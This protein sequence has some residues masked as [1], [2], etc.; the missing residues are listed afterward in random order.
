MNNAGINWQGAPVDM[1]TALQEAEQA[2]E[3]FTAHTDIENVLGRMNA[4]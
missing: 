1:Y 4:Q 2:L 3:E